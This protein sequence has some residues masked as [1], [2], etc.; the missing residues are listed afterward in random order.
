M[1]T[2]NKKWT[3]QET[4]DLISE[5]EESPCLWNVFD[6]GYKNKDMKAAALKKI[7]L[8]LGF[9]VGEIK[10]KLH[11]LRCQYTS[12][13]KKTL[14]K[15][16]GQGASDRYKSQWPYFD[17][18]KFLGSAVNVRET[19]GN[20]RLQPGKTTRS[21]LEATEEEDTSQVGVL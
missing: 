6:K 12:E 17:M 7:A 5:F 9:S 8:S 21:G 10:R 18:L 20:L 11:N 14:V 16:S 13:E 15:K 2:G 1:E 3:P 19:T 4:K